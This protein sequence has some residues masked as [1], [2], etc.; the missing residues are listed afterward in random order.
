[1]FRIDFYS[2]S[3]SPSTANNDIPSL[4]YRPLLY[5][6]IQSPQSTWNQCVRR[7]NI[8]YRLTLDALEQAKECLKQ[9]YSNPQ[10]PANKKSG[11]VTFCLPLP[12]PISHH[13]IEQHKI[14]P[15]IKFSKPKL[16]KPVELDTFSELAIIENDDDKFDSVTNIIKKFNSLSTPVNNEL[17]DNSR[18]HFQSSITTY[19]IPKNEPIVVVEEKPIS[20]SSLK[21]P[22]KFISHIPKRIP[23]NTRL[24]SSSKINSSNKQKSGNIKTRIPNVSSR[25]SIPIKRTSHPK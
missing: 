21:T 12:P 7:L 13:S 3:P 4:H 5:R 22:T 20:S 9:V 11:N 8:E 6:E 1:L 19:E 2:P 25:S 14:L 15:C 17:I 18:V 24:K 10:Y 16:I 23:T